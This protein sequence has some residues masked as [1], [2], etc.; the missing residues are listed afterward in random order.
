MKTFVLILV[1]LSSLLFADAQGTATRDMIKKYTTELVTTALRKADFQRIAI[2]DLTDPTKEVNQFGTYVADLISIYATSVDKV[3]VLDRQNLAM[4]IKEHNLKIKDK[5]IDQNALLELGKF[6]GAQVVLVGKVSILENENT[7][8]LYTKIVDVNTAQT[9]SAMEEYFTVDKR[10]AD[11]SGFAYRSDDGTGGSI[12]TPG[13]GFNRPIESGI[14][15]NN[16]DAASKAC[17]INNTGD[18]CFVNSS[19]YD[20]KVRASKMELHTI[21]PDALF[22][23]NDLILKPGDSK[24]LYNYTAGLVFKYVVDVINFDNS[25]MPVDYVITPA[26][27]RDIVDQGSFRVE[28]CQSKSY[29]IKVKPSA[30]PKPNPISYPQRISW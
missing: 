27:L 21:R 7:F 17:K 6:S 8:Q 25:N 18:F 20:L 2:W 24:C 3:I 4:I 15:T 11:A 1:G 5:F 13:R 22:E 10:F 26:H 23:S 29:T 9:L 14:V 12:I 30:L 19:K 28:Q 16:P